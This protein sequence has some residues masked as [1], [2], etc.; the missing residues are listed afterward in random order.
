MNKLPNTKPKQKTDP[1]YVYGAYKYGDGVEIRVCHDTDMQDDEVKRIA[2]ERIQV[3]NQIQL[4]TMS[5]NP[6]VCNCPCD[7]A[8]GRTHSFFISTIQ[9]ATDEPVDLEAGRR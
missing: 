9:E 4:G 6:A 7:T 1:L 2:K 8:D 5:P 3:N